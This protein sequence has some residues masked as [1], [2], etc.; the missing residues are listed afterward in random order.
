MN[1]IMAI[2]NEPGPLAVFTNMLLERIWLELV[3]NHFGT[4]ALSNNPLSSTKKIQNKKQLR[5]KNLPRVASFFQTTNNKTK[6]R[7]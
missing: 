5:T 3:A 7:P 6:G 2:K 4:S 1:W